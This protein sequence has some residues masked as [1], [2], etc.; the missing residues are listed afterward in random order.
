ME[1]EVYEQREP[2]KTKVKDK[3]GRFII[4]ADLVYIKNLKVPVG[5]CPIDYARDKLGIKFPLVSAANGYTEE[6]KVR[7]K[8]LQ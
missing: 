4:E 2:I 3:L 8:P 7:S 5:K 6:G 1:Y